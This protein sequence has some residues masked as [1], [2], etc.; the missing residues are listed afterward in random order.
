[1]TGRLRR[2]LGRLAA[3]VIPAL[4]AAYGSRR[5]QALLQRPDLQESLTQMRRGDGTVLVPRRNPHE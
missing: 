3:P 5:D 4:D 2:L 1:M